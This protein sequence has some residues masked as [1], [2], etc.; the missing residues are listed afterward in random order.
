MKVKLPT[1]IWTWLIIGI[2]LVHQ[3]K[4]KKSFQKLE[5]CPHYFD[6]QCLG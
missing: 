6:T 1:K 5:H 4:F 2:V 3:K